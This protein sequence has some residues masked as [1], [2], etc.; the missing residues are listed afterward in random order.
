MMILSE[1]F[2]A[3]FTAALG[4][5]LIVQCTCTATLLMQLMFGDLFWIK[6][7]FSYIYYVS[8]YRVEYDNLFKYY[9]ILKLDY[10]I[11]H[12]LLKVGYVLNNIFLWSNNR[13]VS[14]IHTGTPHHYNTRYRNYARVHKHATTLFT[15]RVSNISVGEWL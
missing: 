7:K 15:E 14:N 10:V 12:E 1:V 9:K 13:R 3:L 5:L 2:P 8:L 4:R 6:R 11:K